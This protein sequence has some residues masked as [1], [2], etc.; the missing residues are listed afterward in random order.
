MPD[1][2]ESPVPSVPEVQIRLHEVAKMLRESSTLDGT[3]QRALAEL[4][5]ELGKS[6]ATA[7]LPAAE[8]AQLADSTAQLAESLHH[9]QDRGLLG[10]ARDR[11]E[12]ALLNAESHAPNAVGLARRVLNTLTELGI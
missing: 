9:E 5:A 12:G 4:V 1:T 11:L 10:K 8:V 6:L 2:P 3:S 7:H